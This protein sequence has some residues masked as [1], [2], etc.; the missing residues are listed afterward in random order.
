MQYLVQQ[1]HY[2][3]TAKGFVSVKNSY[4][5]FTKKERHKALCAHHVCASICDVVLASNLMDG[6]F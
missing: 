6:F 5:Y 4:S 1:L 2:M 3:E